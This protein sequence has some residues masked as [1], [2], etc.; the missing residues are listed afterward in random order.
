MI[1][2]ILD[3]SSLIGFIDFVY[4][5]DYSRIEASPKFLER[6]SPVLELVENTLESLILYDVVYVDELSLNSTHICDK[7]YKLDKLSNCHFLNLNTAQKETIYKT[8]FSKLK[9]DTNYINSVL[10]MYGSEQNM[11]MDPHQNF[12]LYGVKYF[13][14]EYYPYE[15]YGK[16]LDDFKKRLENHRIYDAGCKVNFDL[17]FY[18]VVRYFY[19]IELQHMMSSELVLH[20]NRNRL[21]QL[22]SG[23]KK[24]YSNAIISQYEPLRLKLYDRESEWLGIGDNSLLIPMVASYVLTRCKQKGDLFKIINDVRNSKEANLFREGLSELIR[25]V[26][27]RNNKEIDKI[28]ISLEEARTRWNQSLHIHPTMRTKCISFSLPMI[29]GIGMDVDVP[30]SVENKIADKLLTIIHKIL[31]NGN[32]TNCS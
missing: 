21:V 6:L 26:K 1:K 7:L 14:P 19:Y 27:Q 28:L 25:V 2:V 20:P 8:V 4:R 31:I 22:F 5:F 3:T 15:Y 30:Y 32:L 13:Y 23:Y 16:I 9:L 10:T 29:G 11:F 18:H 24:M 17:P 12:S